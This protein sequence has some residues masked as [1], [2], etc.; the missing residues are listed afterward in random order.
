M[1][2]CISKN[3]GS[4]GPLHLEMTVSPERPSLN[5]PVTFQVQVTGGDG[6]PVNDAEVNG[7]LTMKV[8]DMGATHLRF[9]PKGN[10]EYEASVTSLD[11][12][13]PWGLTVTAKHGGAT[14]KQNFDVNV[15]D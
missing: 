4:A 5:K 9:T 15:F 2:G 8:M 7:A 3:S 12:S 13:G 6:Q 14:A 10:G 1:P 11:M